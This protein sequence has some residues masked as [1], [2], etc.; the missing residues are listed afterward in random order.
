MERQKIVDVEPTAPGS[1]RFRFHA[2][3]RD[4]LVEA[5]DTMRAGAL[6]RPVPGGLAG[7]ASLR[8]PQRFSDPV[9]TRQRLAREVGGR[10]LHD[11]ALL[12]AIRDA[13]HQD[14]FR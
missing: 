4:T 8:E 5:R 7:G 11:Q 10:P 1:T 3:K 12:A 9:A 6:L 2:L 13:A 14:R